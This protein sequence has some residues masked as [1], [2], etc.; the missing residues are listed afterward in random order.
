MYFLDY[1]INN[2]VFL[3]SLGGNIYRFPVGKLTVKTK[4]SA[5]IDLITYIHTIVFIPLIIKLFIQKKDWFLKRIKADAWAWSDG[6]FALPET[7]ISNFRLRGQ[8][9]LNMCS[10]VEWYITFCDF[11]RWTLCCRWGIFLWVQFQ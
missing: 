3:Y 2:S 4:N 5:G 11:R 1:S 8:E 6:F 9:K 10:R 7:K